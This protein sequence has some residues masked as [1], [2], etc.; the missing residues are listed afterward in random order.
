MVR[1]IAARFAALVLALIVIAVVAGACDDPRPKGRGTSEAG[2]ELRALGLTT[3][4]PR[5]VETA[6][7]E[8]RRLASVRVVCPE[9]V[10]DVRITDMKGSF[11]SIVFDA[12]PRVYMLSFDKDFFGSTPPPPGVKHWIVGGGDASA[13]QKW[14]FTDFANEVQGDARLMETVTESGYEVRVYEFP[15]YPAGGVNGSHIAALVQ[16]GDEVAFASLHGRGHTDA[17]IAL[18]VHLADQLGTAGPES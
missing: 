7:V 2:D 1:T 5:Q 13:V 10:P 4:V 14:V 6:C 12:E 11:G 3:E 8:A 17:A 9:V 18:A 16:V 15:E